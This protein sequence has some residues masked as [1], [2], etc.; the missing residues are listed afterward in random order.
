MFN[1]HRL[2]IR[3]FLCVPIPVNDYIAFVGRDN[4][5]EGRRYAAY[6]DD[7]TEQMA[8]CRQKVWNGRRRHV[9]NDGTIKL[10]N[11]SSDLWLVRCAEEYYYQRSLVWLR[12]S[13]REDDESCF[14]LVRD[15]PTVLP[16]P[17]D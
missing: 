13:I 8:K 11:R 12:R 14:D 16:P 17:G 2:I 10:A 7:P 1:R 9:G 6:P 15:T 4:I 5:L 3:P